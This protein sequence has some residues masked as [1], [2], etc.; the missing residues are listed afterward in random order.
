MTQPGDLLVFNLKLWHQGTSNPEKTHRRVI[1]WSVGED[2]PGFT[3]F[4]RSF[5]DRV[6]RAQSD[7]PWPE[8]ILR[9][10]PPHRIEMLD[11]FDPG[12]VK[13]QSLATA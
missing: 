5:H 13:Q 7:S 12:S 8:S 4:A 2:K 11:V 1:F 6:G 10:A 9:N 3:E